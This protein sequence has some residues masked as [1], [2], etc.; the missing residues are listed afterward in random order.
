MESLFT[1]LMLALVVALGAVATLW[2][3][4]V[5]RLMIERQRLII[6]VLEEFFKPKD[7]LYTLLGYL[8][9]FK[10]EYL[11][12][13]KGVKKVWALYTTPPLHAFL[14]LPVIRAAK[15]RERIALTIKPEG[16]IPAEAHVLDP[17]D[18]VARRTFTVD[19]GADALQRCGPRLGGFLAC[20][21]PSILNEVDTLIS[22]L[23]SAGIH[24]TRVSID[25]RTNVLHAQAIIEGADP[26]PLLKE[27]RE[28]LKRVTVR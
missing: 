28:L 19:Y 22:R 18:R 10:A 26:R 5:R 23:R 14:Y 13:S 2:F 8:V 6:G 15:G 16:S 25:S 1:Q 27:L 20:G 7:K 21:S 24:V 3:F 9:G 17:K 4:R 12:E 11:V